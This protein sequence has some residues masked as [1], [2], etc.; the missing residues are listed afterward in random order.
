ML[1][2]ILIREWEIVT[3][4]LNLIT[5]HEYEKIFYNISNIAEPDGS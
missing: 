5:L 3:P 1:N 4:I 2:K